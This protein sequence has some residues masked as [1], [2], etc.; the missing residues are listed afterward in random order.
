M[1]LEYIKYSYKLIIKKQITN[2]LKCAKEFYR[3]FIKEDVTVPTKHI[4]ICLISSVK[5]EMHIKTTKI[6][7]YRNKLYHF[8]LKPAIYEIYTYYMPL[9]IFCIVSLAPNSS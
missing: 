3:N 7:C 8:T 1:Y 2:C 6:Y 9:P 4:K 5:K